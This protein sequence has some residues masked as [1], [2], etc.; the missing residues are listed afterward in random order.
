MGAG[1]LAIL[2][3]ESLPQSLRRRAMLHPTESNL[4]SL[5]V[6]N[7]RCCNTIRCATDPGSRDYSSSAVRTI[8]R[9]GLQQITLLSI[10][11]LNTKYFDQKFMRKIAGMTALN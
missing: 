3:Q 7:H 10:D 9:Y 4:W 8:K 6:S 5:D 11:G 2:A 1:R